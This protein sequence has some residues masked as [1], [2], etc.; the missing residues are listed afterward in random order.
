MTLGY[1]VEKVLGVYEKDSEVRQTVGLP[2]LSKIPVLKYF[3]STTT[4]VREKT[5]I[6]VT[7]QAVPVVPEKSGTGAGSRTS[8]IHERRQKDFFED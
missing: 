3:F 2:V 4:V 5:Y 1:N 8:E 6:I 7:A